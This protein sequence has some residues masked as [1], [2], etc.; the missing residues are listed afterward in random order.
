MPPRRFAH[1][2]DFPELVDRAPFG[3]L[4]QRDGA[5]RFEQLND[6]V[7][8]EKN[9]LADRPEQARTVSQTA[10]LARRFTDL[11]ATHPPLEARI[12]RIDTR[13]D[14]TYPEVKHVSADPGESAGPKPGRL[15][16]ILP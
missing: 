12:R 9:L 11:F 4:G 16:R 6:L 2:G 15:P 13:W 5:D 10:L 1:G 3:G 8:W 7:P 14:G